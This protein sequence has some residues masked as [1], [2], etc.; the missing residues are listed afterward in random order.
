MTTTVWTTRFLPYDSNSCVVADG[1]GWISLYNLNGNAW[2]HTKSENL[3]TKP[4]LCLDW[5]QDENGL[6]TFTD[7]HNVKVAYY[8]S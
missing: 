5:N 2:K 1:S 7:L 3:S 4:I 8:S 6:F